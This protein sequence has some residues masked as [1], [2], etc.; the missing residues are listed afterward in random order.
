MPTSH[1]R[2]QASEPWFSLRPRLALS[3][4]GMLFIAVLTLRLFAGDPVDAYSMLYV[5]PVA[6]AATAFGVRGGVFAGLFALALILVW[7]LVRD[8]TLSPTGWATRMV[9][10][11]LLGVLLGR[12]I[13]RQR[14]AETDRRELEA[15]A[16]LHAEA[17]EINDSLVQRM[18][19]AKW[20]LEAGQTDAGL[21]ILTTAVSEAHRLV[22]GLLRRADM[23][24][25]SEALPV[26]AIR[27]ATEE[28]GLEAH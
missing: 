23:G 6:L 21:A 7:I 12:A 13:D 17:I 1:V 28:S 3:V 11:L 26:L 20:A 10:I 2:A 5:L 27:N 9:P 15:A 18:S 16:L 22:S 14:Q 8:V 19:A 25:R 4:I 24:R